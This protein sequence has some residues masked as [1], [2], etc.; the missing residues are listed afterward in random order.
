M[1]E[2]GERF[3]TVI[4]HVGSDDRVELFPG[5]ATSEPHR[6]AEEVDSSFVAELLDRDGRV[7]GRYAVPAGELCADEEPI[8][9]TALMGKVPIPS[10]TAA[11]RIRRD[12]RTLYERPVP[13]EQPEVHMTWDPPDQPGSRE[14]VTWEASHPADLDLYFIVVF[15]NREDD[16]GWRPV[17]LM[18]SATSHEVDL[19]QLPGGLKCR[20]GV[21]CSDGFNTVQ[22]TTAPFELPLRPCQ[23]F[24]VAPLE[25]ERF[26]SGETVV[27]RGQGYWMEEDRPEME[28]LT[29]SSS[30]DGELGRGATVSVAL[31]R[32]QHSVTLRAGYGERIS[33]ASVTVRMDDDGQVAPVEGPITTGPIA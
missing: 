9:G 33:T 4:G 27:L 15:N 32:G 28:E 26:Y 17:S 7:V 21:I 14:T 3:L 30:L 29:W 8:D 1:S 23:A 5:F 31:R 18:T 19:Q 22:A 16:S 6:V 12:D 24:I 10:G 25:G 11:L 20:L 2:D 13:S